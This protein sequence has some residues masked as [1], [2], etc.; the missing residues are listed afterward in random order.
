MRLSA[1]PRNTSL[2]HVS[3]AS[4]GTHLHARRAANV[5]SQFRE[6]DGERYLCAHDSRDLVVGVVDKVGRCSGLHLSLR[7]L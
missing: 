4:D 1:H 2:R 7:R 6:G 5:W 3:N